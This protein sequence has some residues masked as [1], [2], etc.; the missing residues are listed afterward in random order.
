MTTADSHTDIEA[1]R[2]EIDALKAE[3]AQLRKPG[4]ETPQRLTEE[5]QE[6]LRQTLEN[7]RA[8]AV[9][10]RLLERR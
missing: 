6:E 7:V 3:L 5:L 8:G 10:A 4:G 2:K 1:L 9:M